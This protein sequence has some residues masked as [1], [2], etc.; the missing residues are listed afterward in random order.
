[1]SKATAQSRC[2]KLVRQKIGYDSELAD[3]DPP[4]DCRRRIHNRCCAGDLRSLEIGQGVREGRARRSAQSIGTERVLKRRFRTPR[5]SPPTHL[6][7]EPRPAR[8]VAPAS[9]CLGPFKFAIH[10]IAAYLQAMPRKPIELPPAAARSFAKDMRLYHA[11]NDSIKRDEIAER[12]A[13]LLSEHLGPRE[14]QLRL[15]DVKEMFV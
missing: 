6:R 9:P 5:E 10:G 7:G 3:L 12:Q 15:I 13:W 4:L 1:M 8:L 14:K 11:S 2:R